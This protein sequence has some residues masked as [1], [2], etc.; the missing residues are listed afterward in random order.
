M[1]TPS[2]LASLVVKCAV[3]NSVAEHSDLLV[4]TADL[5]DPVLRGELFAL[6]RNPS[7]VGPVVIREA[8]SDG[9]L[10]DGDMPQPGALYE[11]S[12]GKPLKDGW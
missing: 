6:R 2:K 7:F 9:M 12:I 11:V 4:F 5:G 10:E 8:D 1:T 3:P